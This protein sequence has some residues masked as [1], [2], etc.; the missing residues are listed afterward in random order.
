MKILCVSDIHGDQDSIV[1]V[2]NY[3]VD[4][5]IGHV[6]LL[7]DYSVGFK[8]PNENRIDLEYAL[9]LLKGDARVYALPGNCDQRDVTGIL[10]G[11]NASL[12][13]SLVELGGVTFVGLGGSN[14]T[15]F[16]TPFE[17]TEDEI[18]G[19][20]SALMEKAGTGNVFLITHFPPKDTNCDRIPS[21]VHVG[22]SSLRQVI[23][24]KQPMAN[25]CSHIH[26]S[27]GKAD[28]IGETQIVNV[29]MLSH[30]NA[31]LID[32]QELGVKHLLIN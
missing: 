23:E 16:E 31:V 10:D 32:T 8:D 3:L 1:A 5:D 19:R 27:A 20:L 7:G 13:D 6:F 28:K 21:G 2:R 11:H 4:N 29:G 24:E 14:P 25:V 12:H 30:G 22:S 17:L 9:E 15:P 18:Y 26:E